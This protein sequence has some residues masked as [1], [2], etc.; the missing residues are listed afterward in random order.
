[1]GKWEKI[2]SKE[3]FKNKWL[4]LRVDKV[5]TP[6]GKDGEYSVVSTCKSIAVVAR[7]HADKILLIKLYRY[8]TQNYSWEVIKGRTD[9][10]EPL[11]AAKRELVEETGYQAE[12]WIETGFVHPLN[13]VFSESTYSFI[14]TNLIQTGKNEQE[15]EGITEVK[16][17]GLD[18]IESM[19]QNNT[20]TDGQSICALW[21][22]KLYWEK[23]NG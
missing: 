17:F 21:K 2:S 9:G 13:G 12:E 10:E 3:V 20:I 8:P 5:I 1:M 14:A 16:A 22:A 19:I 15:E 7:D 4:S 18:E 6:D 11:S 23:E